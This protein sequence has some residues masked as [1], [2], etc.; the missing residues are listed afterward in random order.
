MIAV[1][2]VRTVKVEK[3]DEVWAIVR[4]WRG[5]R[6]GIKQVVAL[7][8]SWDL[9]KWYRQQVQAGT[10]GWEAFELGYVPR[11]LQE[12]HSAEARQALNELWR[13]DKAGK[14]V[15]ICCFCDDYDLC[16]RS[17]VAGMLKGAGC[18]VWVAGDYPADATYYRE[19]KNG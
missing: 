7:S 10:W 12:M 3:Y 6:S 14:R 8:P 1:E 13:L 11:F 16:H 15:A 17:I 2:N 19:W 5:G 18:K 4:S 9:F